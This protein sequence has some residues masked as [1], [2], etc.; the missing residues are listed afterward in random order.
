MTDITWII[1]GTI[2]VLT[3]AITFIVIPLIKSKVSVDEW[4]LIYGKIQNV[5]DWVYTAVQAAEV[6]FKGVGLGNEKN[7]WV[8]EFVKNRC[9]KYNITFDVDLVKAEIENAGIKLHL[10]GEEDKNEIK[11][12]K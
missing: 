12:D 11:S 2:V 1:C 9:E 6:F 4:N 5:K 7:T 10:W 8:L 3:T